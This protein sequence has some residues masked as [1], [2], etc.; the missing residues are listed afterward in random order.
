MEYAEIATATLDQ[1]NE[2][3]AAAGWESGYTEIDWARRAARALFHQH[4][5]S[6]TKTITVTWEEID[7]VGRL[8]ARCDEDSTLSSSVVRWDEP[9]SARS[10][11]GDI[12]HA[13]TRINGSEVASVD[14]D[15]EFVHVHV[16]A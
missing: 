13:V 3:L 11:A 14:H 16:F 8:I 12:A 4:G 5:K 6:Q 1:L 9:I 15:G 2:E 7:G 10:Y